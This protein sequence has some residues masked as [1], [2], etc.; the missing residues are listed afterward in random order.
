MAELRSFM[1]EKV[2]LMDKAIIEEKRAYNMVSAMYN[3]YLND[4][5]LLPKRYYKLLDN[6]D[7][8]TV[9]CDYLSSMTDRYAIKTFKEIFVPKNFDD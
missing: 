3:Y 2:Y 8:H 4:L 7:K 9:V 6:Y 1:F 5:T